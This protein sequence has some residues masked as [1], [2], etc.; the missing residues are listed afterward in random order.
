[1]E[2]ERFV[3]QSDTLKRKEQRIDYV[4]IALLIIFM[5]LISGLPA[6]K[7]SICE[8]PVVLY[9]RNADALSNWEEDRKEGVHH[10]L[11]C[12]CP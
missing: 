6:K 9:P 5:I 7:R 1:M 8:R 4:S 12:D 10:S 11:N 2:F 3:R